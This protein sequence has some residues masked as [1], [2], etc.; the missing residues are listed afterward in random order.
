[1]SGLMNLIRTEP[2]LIVSLVQSAIGV[3]TAFGLGWTAEQVAIILSFTGTLLAVIA[4]M[5]VTPTTNVDQQVAE[6]VAEQSSA[7]H[8]GLSVAE[9]AALDAQRDAFNAELDAE[10]KRHDWRT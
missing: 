4:R 7:N 5:M 6:Q 3:G 1:M 8:A 9:L 2:V 10:M